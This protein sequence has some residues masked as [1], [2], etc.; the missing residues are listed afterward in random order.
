MNSLDIKQI[1]QQM[2]QIINIEYYE[3]I[4]STHNY[5]KKAIDSLKDKTVIIAEKQTG[6]IGTKGRKWHTG[7]G[8]NIAMTIVLKANYDIKQ[9]DGYTVK[10]AQDIKKSIN[11][12]YGYELKI[13][14]PNDLM[15]NGKKICGIL[16]E[17]HTIG[18]KVKYILISFGFN[19]NEDN[20][21]EEIKNIATSLK[22]E[23]EKEFNREEIIISILNKLI[24]KD[25][26]YKN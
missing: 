24:P 2:D 6:G 12:L 1:K 26:D 18:E 3:E 7:E 16:T 13:K 15:L 20:F 14:E 19:V 8:K 22:K 17:I 11:E 25:I 10:I 4:D 23:Y 5:A 9:L 21:N